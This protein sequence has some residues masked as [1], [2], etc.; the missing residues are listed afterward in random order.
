MQVSGADGHAARAPRNLTYL[1]FFLR[2]HLY[3]NFNFYSTFITQIAMAFVGLRIVATKLVN[4]TASRPFLCPELV[5]RTQ[6]ALIS[7]RHD[8]EATKRPPP[9][10]YQQKKFTKFHCL[11]DNTLKRLNENSKLVVVEGNI[12]SGKSAFAKELAQELDM[13]YMPE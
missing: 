3:R 7:G 8:K 1:E 9:F 13:L 5:A 4:P 10:P 11:F 2:D 6:V 12:A